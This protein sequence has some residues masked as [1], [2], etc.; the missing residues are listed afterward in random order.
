M[1]RDAARIGHGELTELIRHFSEAQIKIQFGEM[2]TVAAEMAI[3]A[4]CS[5]KKRE[6][7]LIARLAELEEKAQQLLPQESTGGMI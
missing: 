7:G 5:T 2:K 3:A 6:A 4:A 1:K